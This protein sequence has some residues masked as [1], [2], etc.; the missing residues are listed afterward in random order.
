MTATPPAAPRLRSDRDFLLFLTS[1]SVAVLGSAISA[2]ALPLLVFRLSG[3]PLVTSTVAAVQVMPYL[4]FGLLAGAVADRAP[5]RTL[6]VAA[7]A[8][9]AVALASVPAAATI[10]ELHTA[11][12]VTVAAV[13][14]TSF[15]WFDAAA[16]GALPTLVGTDRIVAANSAIWTVTT[17]LGVGAPALGGLLVSVLGAPR[18]L[19]LDAGSYVAAGLLLALIGRSM[20]PART[21]DDS[22]PARTGTVCA[23]IAEGLRFLFGQPLIRSLT[24]LGIG[25]SLT[26]GA[27]TA[28]LVVLVVDTLDL[29]ADGRWYGILLAAVAL[30]GLLAALALPRLSGRIR[31]GTIT[32]AGLT[33]C[34]VAVL[35]VAAAPGPGRLIVPLLLWSTAST[36]VILNGITARQ[37]LTPD[38][39]QGRVNTTARMVAWGGTPLG[40]LAAGGL[41]EIVDVRLALVISATA[42]TVS[43][44][45]GWWSPLRTHT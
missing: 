10:G 17:L 45:T 23:D 6:M 25:N 15:V 35:A 31:I 38:R 37:R 41:A 33:A 42:V 29:P 14:A 7:Q 30:G 3:S 34:P 16:F 21:A 5:R 12:M 28:L 9:A 26:G 13:V 19:A 36:L 27:V 1:R 43:A 40:A 24:L 11:H 2:V 20:D 8:C 39:L 4:L 22:A 18:A 44:I 32:L